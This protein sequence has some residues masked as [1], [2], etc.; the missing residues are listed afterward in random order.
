MVYCSFT[1]FD[2]LVA[3]DVWD[4][5]VK[6]KVS[7][8]IDAGAGRKRSSEFKVNGIADTFD[9]VRVI[10]DDDT[11][12]LVDTDFDTVGSTGGANDIVVHPKQ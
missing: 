1:F 8:A 5:S 7:L 6:K 11:T 4:V 9:G 10:D 2:G 3:D 12:G